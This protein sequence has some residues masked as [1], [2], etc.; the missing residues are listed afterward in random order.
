M[1]INKLIIEFNKLGA[2]VAPSTVANWVKNG[3]PCKK[4]EKSFDLDLEEVVK[5]LKDKRDCD[6]RNKYYCTLMTVDE[7]ADEF[8]V[9][10]TLIQYYCR[11]RNLPFHRFINN[12]LAFDLEEVKEWRK[13]LKE[14][15]ECKKWEKACK[16]GKAI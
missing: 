8:N 2:N 11:K 16:R 13:K 10:K 14:E 5:C 15:R 1:N 12:K 4:K 6:I 9:H 7:L 3:M